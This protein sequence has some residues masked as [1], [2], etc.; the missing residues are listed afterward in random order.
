MKAVCVVD[1]TVFMEILNVPNK[2]SRRAEIIAQLEEK[3]NSKE[4]LFLPMATVLETGN[5]IAQNG[6]GSQRRQC[7]ERFVAQVQLAI[8]G[9]SPFTSINFLEADDMRRWLAEFP[10]WAMQAQGLGDLSIVHD[11]ERL[12]EQNRGRRVYIWSLDQHLSGYDK[13][14]G[15]AR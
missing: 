5:H 12:C 4:S 7:A 13:P 6:D 11:W 8:D 15:V 2:A 10:D 9:N 3:I 14:A 1:T